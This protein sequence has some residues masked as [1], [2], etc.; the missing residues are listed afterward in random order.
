[1][2]KRNKTGHAPSPFSLDEPKYVANP[3]AG[4][5]KKR[6]RR[7]Q[8]MRRIF[9]GVLILGVLM[10]FANVV[11]IANMLNPKAPP[12][13]VSSMDVNQSPGKS[14]AMQAMVSWLSATPQPVDGGHVLSWDGVQ[15][16]NPPAPPKDAKEGESKTYPNYTVEVHTFTVADSA[17]YLYEGSI[18]VEANDLMGTRVASTPSLMPI[19]PSAPQ[20]EAWGMSTTWFGWQDAQAQDPV[21]K[22][23]QSWAEALTS[24]DPVK[25]RQ[26]VGDTDPSRAYMP[27]GVAD[28]TKATVTA[29]AVKTP[30][31]KDQDPDMSV[32]LIR[33]E[34]LATLNGQQVSDKENQ[35][36]PI[37]YDLLVEGADTAA[38]R[39]VSWGAAGTGATLTPY[40]VAVTGREPTAMQ[41]PDPVETA[42][43]TAA[44]EE[45]APKPA[46]DAKPK[47]TET[48]KPADDGKAETPAPM[49]KK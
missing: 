20:G 49:P 34:V 45:E 15:V 4:P 21:A 26:A 11:L 1:M 32:M 9:T 29:S 40:S 7:A 36:S 35:R 39:V 37:T 46:G 28:D 48:T 31:S 8:S 3:E 33:V 30:E 13:S 38:P 41:S 6:E 23:V 24:G 25:L 19:A 5:V 43:A 44:P 42:P 22:S 47:P 16:I 18:A 14:L 17:G 10:I 2:G 27:L 12:A